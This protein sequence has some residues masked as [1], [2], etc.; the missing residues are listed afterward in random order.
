MPTF[1]S[2]EPLNVLLNQKKEKKGFSN[3]IL[4]WWDYPGLSGW[5]YAPSKWEREARVSESE[6]CEDSVLL[7]LNMEERTNEPGNVD[8]L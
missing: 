6:I 8:D 5:T 7:I 2:L 4:R 3:V 1:C